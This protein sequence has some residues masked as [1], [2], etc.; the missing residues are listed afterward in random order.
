[1]ALKRKITKDAFEK[2]ADPLKFEYKA[3]PENENEY[4]LDVDD[5]KELTRALARE[6]ARADTAEEAAEVA[7]TALADLERKRTRKD[8]DIDTLTATHE[9]EK[10]ELTEG[11]TTKIKAK[12]AFIQETLVDNVAQALAH[13]ISSQ[14]DLIL[15]HVKA[16]ITAD[17]TGEKPVT[18]IIGPDGKPSDMTVDKLAE[19]FVANKKFSAIIIGSKAS[20]GSAPRLGP[21]VPAL[22]SAAHNPEKPASLATMK[23]ADLAASLKA[24][25]EQQTGA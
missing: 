11:F 8:R 20:G 7:T 18:K 17:L 19:E 1:M 13:K 23:P 3:N 21:T 22:G 6:K 16:R 9:R 2:L 25:R 5:A 15:P 12:D 24:K 4:L 14:P 10:T